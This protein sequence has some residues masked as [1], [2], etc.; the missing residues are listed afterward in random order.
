VVQLNDIHGTSGSDQRDTETK[1]ESASHE[2]RGARG[3]A[4]DSCTDDDDGSA[5]EH[6]DAAA[7][8]IHGRADKGKSDNTTNLV[9]G[10]DDARPDAIVVDRVVLLEP[11]V[12]QQVVDEGSIVAVDG[13]AEETDEGEG[14]HEQLTAG[15]SARWLLDHGLVESLISGDDLAI[16]SL[17]ESFGQLFL[18]L[19]M[20]QWHNA[21]LTLSPSSWVWT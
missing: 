3:R 7:E 16:N 10:R 13:A 15:P 11:G 19:V 1:K 6:A 2:L 14:V 4:L 17:L 21:K 18:A 12:L 9:H 5:E 20:Y 8:A